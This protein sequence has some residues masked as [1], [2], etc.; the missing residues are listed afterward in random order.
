[1]GG[2]DLPQTML[3]FSGGLS[4]R[5]PGGGCGLS[6]VAFVLFPFRFDQLKVSKFSS[7]SLFHFSLFAFHLVSCAS[8]VANG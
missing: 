6:A 4:P 8:T 2:F 3:F 5:M 1:M 7:S